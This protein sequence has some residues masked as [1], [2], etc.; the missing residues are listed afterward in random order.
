MP[1]DTTSTGTV[2]NSYKPQGVYLQ[3]LG[4]SEKPEQTLFVSNT[5]KSVTF[6]KQWNVLSGSGNGEE[7]RTKF[8][9]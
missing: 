7:S 3:L 9:C 6:K 5:L 4:I 1:E 8:S 2:T